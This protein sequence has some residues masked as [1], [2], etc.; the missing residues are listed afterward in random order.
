MQIT[1]KDIEQIIEERGCLRFSTLMVRFHISS[2]EAMEIVEKYN[3]TGKIPRVHKSI[4]GDDPISSMEKKEC[5]S[6]NKKGNSP[7]NK[8]EEPAKIESFSAKPIV[9]RKRRKNEVEG[10]LSFL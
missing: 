2:T 4:A 1:K 8:P 6:L 7:K 3:K 5:F 10:Q 9:S